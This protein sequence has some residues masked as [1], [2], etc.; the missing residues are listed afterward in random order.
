MKKFLKRLSIFI[1]IIAGLYGVGRLVDVSY[2]SFEFVEREPYM[3][4]QTENSITVK[5]QT[6]K[7]EIGKVNYSL[8]SA[9]LE[10]SILEKE[11]TNKHSVT[12]KNLDECTKYRYSVESE[13]LKIDNEGRSFKT[14]CKNSATQRL[15]VIGDSGERGEG[16]WTVYKQ[17][18][19][20]INNDFNK[21]DMWILLGDNAYRSGTQEEYNT[22]LFEAYKELVK[23]FVPWAVTGNHDARRWSFYSIWDFPQNG[24]SGGVASGSDEFYSI[25]NGNLH[26]VMMDSEHPSLSKDGDM[27]EWLRKDLSA[28]KKPWVIVAFHTPPYTDGSHKS[29]SDYN[30]GGRM[31]EMRENFV[32][33]FD[34]FGVDLV[35]SGH[36]HAYERSK[37]MINHT[38]KSNTFDSAKYI[39]QDSKTCYT[40]SLGKTKNSGTV[41]LVCGSSSKLNVSSLK[42]PAMPFGFNKMGSVILEVTPTT[43]TSKFLTSDGIIADKFAINKD[44]SICTNEKK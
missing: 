12:I 36:S 18:L 39:V 2:G 20:Y 34:E 9:N 16:Q 13:S 33:I 30:S 15:W 3:V 25:D 7:K 19:D 27:A 10:K 6:D 26:I 4:M 21:L 43:L 17:M 5:W 1:V 42:H 44:K 40:K 14:L 22:D 11:S 24:E 28:N 29:D 8:F 31:K 37:L 35:L 38:G 32:P 23:R 41:Y